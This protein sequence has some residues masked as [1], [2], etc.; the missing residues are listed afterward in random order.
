MLHVYMGCAG[1]RKVVDSDAGKSFCVF[2]GVSAPA[3]VAF[4]NAPISRTTSFSA[5]ADFLSRAVRLQPAL[6][7]VEVEQH[8]SADPEDCARFGQPVS[9]NLMAVTRKTWLCVMNQR[10]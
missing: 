7:T 6:K 8:A 4:G 3:G 1:D 9:G 10:P 5:L 2:H